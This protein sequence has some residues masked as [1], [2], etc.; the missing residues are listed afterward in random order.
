[1]KAEIIAVGTE[2][3]TGYVTNTNGSWLAKE[4]MALGIGTY[5]QS[6]VGDNWARLKSVLDIASQRAD[7]I[8][9]IG[10]LGPT[11]DDITKELVAE[12]L[13]ENLEVN[14]QQLEKIQSYFQANGRRAQSTDIKQAYDI[15]HSI[16]LPNPVGLALG[17][18]YHRQDE[19]R[20]QYFVLLPGPPFELKAMFE[21]SVKDYFRTI[22]VQQEG[23]YLESTY[24]NFYNLGE[25]DL[26]QRIDHLIQKQINPTLA[27]YAKPKQVTVRLTA[28]GETKMA[29]QALNQ[30]RSQEILE[31]IG[32]YYIGE[33]E[34]YSLADY[35]IGA[36]Q[37]RQLTLATAE[38]LTG[39]LVCQQLTGIPGASHVIKG[40]FI[41]YQTQAKIDILGLSPDL[42]RE[43]S[44]YSHEVAQ[45]MAQAARRLT[46]AYLGIGLSGVAGPGPDQGREPG[47]VYIC[48]VDEKGNHLSRQLNL[49]GE[50]RQRVRELS[51]LES[52]GLVKDYLDS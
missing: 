29:A 48:L 46:H 1:M 4:L 30:A 21:D 8:L 39:G 35:I 33:G 17:S 44:V 51:A 24:L 10:G 25:A 20:D 34:N 32:D 45:A 47:T 37:D 18:F 3:L 22:V 28:S 50:S 27:T 6:T 38:S 5:Y 31:I 49:A 13:G 42:I 12:Y 7:V 52:L 9:L 19:D 2:V 23:R 41:T 14:H 43:K 15:G 26:A 36:L 11:R 40:G 16:S